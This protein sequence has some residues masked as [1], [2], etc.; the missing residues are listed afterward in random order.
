MVNRDIL[1]I[2]TEENIIQ[3]D[4]AEK[5]RAAATQTSQAIEEILITQNLVA[6]E[7]VARASGIL[8]GLPYIDL[9]DRAVPFVILSKFP[10]EVARKYNMAVFD[11]KEEKML[12]VALA[13]PWDPMTEQA[14][15][16]IKNKNHIAIDPYVTT[17]EGFEFVLSQYATPVLQA[18]PGVEASSGPATQA[19]TA[20]ANPTAQGGEKK[21]DEKKEGGAPKADTSLAALV[22][23]DI[24]S[25]EQLAKI[26]AESAVPRIVAA[27]IKYAVSLKASDIHIE[28]AEKDSRVRYRV[29]GVLKEIIKLPKKTHP[30][31]ASR[32]K[33]LAKL[34]ID[35]QRLPQDGRIEV[36]FN[37]LEIDLR[38]STLPVIFGEKIVMRI[39]DK[40]GGVLTM[41]QMLTGRNYELLSDAIKRPFGIILVTGPTGSGKSTTIYALLM[42]LNTQGVN[43][44]TLED[45]VE[46]MIEGINQVQV[47][48]QIGLTFAEGLRSFLR[49]DPNIIMVGEVRDKETAENA[50]QAALTGHLVLSTLHT[51]SAAGAIPRLID[52][53]IEPFLIT[54][55]IHT[56][57]AQRLVRRICPNCKEPVKLGP[58][59]MDDLKKE[60][61]KIPDSWKMNRSLSESSVFFHGKGCAKCNNTGYKGR[62]S[63]YEIL[64]MSEEIERLAVKKVSAGDM[65]AEAL[66][67]GMITMKQDG[68]LKV[69]DGLTTMEEV[70]RVTQL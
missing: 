1:S 46:Y 6:P 7:E 58:A 22:K 67:E 39:L 8:L 33:I 54:S 4:Q 65:L 50:I 3:A 62:L 37:N 47:K 57:I 13:K 70:Y 17:Q 40:T 5:I 52:M 43:I 61:D 44:L 68:V 42:K 21:P 41:E 16:F 59:V 10:E 69:V 31:I 38:V 53:G 11:T 45:P 56:I 19:P 32:I 34:K 9:R 66:K 27:I 36:I 48:P 64:T 24:T 63:L 49:Q 51:N 15:D 23:E 14:L 28:P 12:K 60:F 35:E 20:P 29:D 55:S 18:A 2:L 26:A 30:A 25:D